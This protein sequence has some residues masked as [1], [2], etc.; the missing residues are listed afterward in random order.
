MFRRPQPPRSP[1]C[2]SRSSPARRTT[3]GRSPRRAAVS[4]PL[5]PGEPRPS[6]AWYRGEQ[7]KR[8]RSGFALEDLGSP[9]MFVVCSRPH[10][11]TRSF[12]SRIPRRRTRSRRQ[13]PTSSRRPSRASVCPACSFASSMG[14]ASNTPTACGGRISP[15]MIVLARMLCCPHSTAIDR[16]SEFTPDLA[17][18]AARSRSRR[19]ASCPRRC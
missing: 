17:A 11:R 3:G 9:G 15:T 10:R 18:P 6:R 8:F 13:L 1:W 4:P 16:V 12:R 5:S 7:D 19:V 2:R 14:S